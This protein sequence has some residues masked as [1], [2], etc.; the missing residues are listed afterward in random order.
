[1]ANTLTNLKITRVALVDKGA[2]QHAHIMLFKADSTAA[3]HSDKPL[4]E[5]ETRRRAVARQALDSALQAKEKRVKPNLLKRMI[6]AM[7]MTD[8]AKRDLELAD[9]VK[10]VDDG[11]ADDTK[12]MAHVPGDPNCKCADCMK[13]SADDSDF[14]KRASAE[15]IELKKSLDAM[16]KRTKDAED[17]AKTAEDVAKAER[18]IRKRADMVTLLKSF[19]AVP[20]TLE[21]KEGET[22]DVDRYLKM[23]DVDPDG[24]DR[25]IALLKA[26]DGQIATG[27]MFKSFGSGSSQGGGDAWTQIE[28]KAAAMMEKSAGSMTKEQAINKAMDDNPKLVTQYRAEQQ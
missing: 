16:E 1:M 20:L 12:K 3:V 23:Q 7:T 28:A 14:G 27:A 10:A 19:K 8:V 5:E 18:T 24:F 26:A 6:A 21:A 9:I 15:V 11:D 2:N 22:S 25:T 13:K 4:S 17:R